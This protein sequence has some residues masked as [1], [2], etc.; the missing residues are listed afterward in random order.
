MPYAQ[1]DQVARLIPLELTITLTRALEQSRELNDIYCQDEIVRNLVDS[2]RKVEGLIRHAST[3]AAGVVI[4]H[5]PLTEYV[6][7][8]PV[9]KGNKHAVMTQFHME[10]IARLGLL[11][12]DFLG[13]SN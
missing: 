8:Q 7:V 9:A 1:V 10:N 12:I 3:H 4:S 13:L 5:D 11:K 2:A 6:P